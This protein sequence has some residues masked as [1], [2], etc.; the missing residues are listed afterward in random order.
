MTYASQNDLIERYGEKMLIGLTD[1]SSPPVGAIDADVVSRA[2]EDAD[3]MID[4]YL[5]GRY[6][7]PLAV[8][9][10]LVRDQALPIAIYKLHRDIASNKVRADYEDA[11]AILKQISTGTVRLDVAGDEPPSSGTS[12][13]R[14]NDRDPIFTPDSMK[15]FV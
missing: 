2:L 7:L 12:G 13:A 11:L 15:G 9:P 3:A 10:P 1:R 5:A 14:T 4:G 6:R 8:T